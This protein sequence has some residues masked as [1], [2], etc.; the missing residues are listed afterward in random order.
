[1]HEH[2]QE[3]Y[4]VERPTEMRE[5]G[6]KD[7][8]GCEVALR[9]HYRIVTVSEGHPDRA[10]GTYYRWLVEEWRIGQRGQRRV[11]KGW[12]GGGTCATPEEREQAV[13]A[14]VVERRMLRWYQFTLGLKRLGSLPKPNP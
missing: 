12:S 10:P 2:E 11:G 5:V 1:V 7:P 8:Q 3:R 9:V 4:D 6:L 14:C 13:A